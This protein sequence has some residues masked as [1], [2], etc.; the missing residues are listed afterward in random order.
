MT[1]FHDGFF[2]KTTPEHDELVALTIDNLEEIVEEIVPI[3]TLI[4]E[5][6][7][8]TVY[9]CC[10]ENRTR[11][12]NLKEGHR[13]ARAKLPEKHKKILRS[14]DVAIVEYEK[15]GS[16]CLNTSPTETSI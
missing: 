3:K 15:N 14:E 16:L 6:K 4:D 10:H 7:E 5:E 2:R 12:C 8:T 1:K 11:F 13:V 9:I